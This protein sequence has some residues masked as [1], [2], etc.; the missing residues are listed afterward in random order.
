[1]KRA[2]AVLVGVALGLAWAGPGFT[3]DEP[4]A[5][6]PKSRASELAKMRA[7]AQTIVI[8]QSV[9]GQ[10]RPV[11]LIEPA[12]LN[13]ADAGG[14][15]T[16]GTIWVF[17]KTGRPA[18]M[19]GVFYLRHANGTEKWSCELLSLSEHPLGMTG[20]SGWTWTP[21]TGGLV[22]KVLSGPKPA[23]DARPRA[24][25]MKN[26]ARKF[27][28]SESADGERWDE[29]RLMDRPLYK[30]TDAEHEV[31]DGQIFSFAIGT[32]PEALLLLE[33]RGPTPAEGN[34]HYAFARMGA[35][36][37]RA[38]IDEMTVWDVPPIKVWKKNEAYYSNFGTEDVVFGD[39]RSRQQ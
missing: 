30:Y 2:F 16:D 22:W 3:A 38:K 35:S 23:A 5:E 36:E 12:V 37:E 25:Q 10:D 29:T 18:A 31:I 26:L 11:E 32:N 33:C 24:L 19:S 4:E 1:M 20:K 6:A 7:N 9:E 13:Y 17:G 28:V 14:I 39:K 8:V 27:T 15:T 21:E 34:W